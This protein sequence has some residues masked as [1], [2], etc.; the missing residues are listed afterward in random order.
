M[1]TVLLANSVEINFDTFSVF[2][3]VSSQAKTGLHFKSTRKL[4]RPTLLFY[5]N[6]YSW[7]PN[8]KLA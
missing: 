7:S 3:K 4:V 6:F 2:L 1:K 8:V 5:S